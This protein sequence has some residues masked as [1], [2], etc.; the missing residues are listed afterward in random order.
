VRRTRCCAGRSS[1]FCAKLLGVRYGGARAGSVCL[2][3]HACAHS[4]WPAVA[5]S[6]TRHSGAGGCT[7]RAERRACFSRT[8]AC[9]GLAGA[10][11]CCC[12]AYGMRLALAACPRLSSAQKSTY[13]SSWTKSMCRVVCARALACVRVPPAELGG[14]AVCAS[15]HDSG[16][17]SIE[18]GVWHSPARGDPQSAS[19]PGRQHQHHDSKV[20]LLLLASVA[21]LPVHRYDVPGLLCALHLLGV[22][23]APL[24]GVCSG[25]LCARA[26]DACACALAA[27]SR[28]AWDTSSDAGRRWALVARAEAQRCKR[29]STPVDSPLGAGATYVAAAAAAMDVETSTLS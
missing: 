20:L 12:C 10:L 23:C 2:R 3:L 24:P 13:E 15:T 29:S 8:S 6:G 22:N 17:R 9:D 28:L 1:G 7:A 4:C 14:D 11:A 18:C 26:C 16:A 5:A 27:A 21:C 19:Q 25:E